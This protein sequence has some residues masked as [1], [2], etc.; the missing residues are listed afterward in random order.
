MDVVCGVYC[1][2]NLINH[3]KYIGQSIDIY[4]RWQDHKNELNG[5][6][7]RNTY[8]Q[9]SWEKYKEENFCFYIL[10]QC[11]FEL[12]DEVETYYIDLFNCNDNNYGYNIEPGGNANKKLADET[13]AKISQSR[14]GKY[15]GADNANAHPVYCP[16]LNRSFGC[17]LDV[18][19]EGIACASSVR[20]CL[21][22]RYKTAGKHP[23]TGL[24]LTWVDLK[25][26][27]K[28]AKQNKRFST[29][30][31]IYCVE[32]D[33]T[34]DSPSQ[35]ERAK[36]ASR[37]CVARCLRGERKSAGKHPVTGKPLHWKYIQNNNT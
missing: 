3:K 1:I 7:H 33:M 13:K 29:N 35:I 12:L 16:E 4:R 30:N 32:L 31:L 27:D 14:I 17:I 11:N 15:R 2:E 6:R 9:R 18:E 8:L 19:S 24:P 10:E 36:V 22:G 21:R 23:D 20:S 5:K 25:I 28:V 34:F 37:T 26:K